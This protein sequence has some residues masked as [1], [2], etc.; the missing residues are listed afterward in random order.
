MY[1]INIPQNNAWWSK[2]Y[3][4]TTASV[5][6]LKVRTNTRLLGIK[7]KNQ[8]GDIICEVCKNE[9][10]DLQHFLLKG[11]DKCV[12]FHID[13]IKLFCTQ[14]NYLFTYFILSYLVA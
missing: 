4:I 5:T 1:R 6:L 7:R 9:T 3:V 13:N 14:H 11:T 12:L 2:H 8:G 10:K